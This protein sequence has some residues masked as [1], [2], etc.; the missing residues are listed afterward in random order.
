MTI[1]IASIIIINIAL[2]TVIIKFCINA[3]VVIRHLNHRISRIEG[4]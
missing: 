1:L 3:N 4:N 2:F